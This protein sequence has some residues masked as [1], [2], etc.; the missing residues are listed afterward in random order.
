MNSSV[1]HAA[2]TNRSHA[3]RSWASQTTRTGRSCRSPRTLSPDDLIAIA[4]SRDA[5]G[6]YGFES[7]FTGGSGGHYVGGEWR[8]DANHNQL[9][10]VTNSGQKPAD[11]PAYA[12]L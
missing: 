5:T 8:Y 10:S 9:V 12:A 3:K 1:R 11:A 6:R 2:I 7:R 4:S